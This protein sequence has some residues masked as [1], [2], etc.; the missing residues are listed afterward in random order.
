MAARPELSYPRALGDSM[1]KRASNPWTAA[2]TAAF[3][4]GAVASCNKSAPPEPAAA[5]QPAALTQQPSEQGAS[6]S[7]T[8]AAPTPS[9]APAAPPPTAAKRGP[10]SDFVGYPKPGW[11]KLKLQDTLPLCVF[12]DAT[13]REQAPFLEQ[14]KKQQLKANQ[15]VVFGAFGPYC[16]NEACD[17]LPSLQCVVDRE[18]KTLKVRARYIGY[19]KDGTTCS[20]DCRQVTAGCETPKLEPGRYKVQYGDETYTLKIPS[21][22]RSPCLKTP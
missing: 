20:D 3:V 2:A 14:V 15:S 16:I 7:S 13:A 12:A 6:T 9:Q 22:M 1:C 11:S 4:L 5:A 10:S 21:V 17:D 18:G 19:H 8:P